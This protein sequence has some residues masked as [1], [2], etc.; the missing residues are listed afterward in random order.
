MEPSEQS[1]LDQALAAELSSNE[2]AAV[3]N[4]IL[5]SME[6]EIRAPRPLRPQSRSTRVCTI[7][8]ALG[9]ILELWELLPLRT[10]SGTAAIARA[11]KRP[12]VLQLIDLRENKIGDAAAE[13]IVESLL[14][15]V[16][17]RFPQV[18]LG[19]SNAKLEFLYSLGEKGFRSFPMKDIPSALWPHALARVSKYPRCFST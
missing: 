4:S 8:H 12:S 16:N 19:T 15:T 2:T 6:S 5:A 7:F 14:V 18:R 11:L 3:I 13:A 9:T 1:A 17:T 10:H